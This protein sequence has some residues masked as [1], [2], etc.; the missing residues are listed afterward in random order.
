MKQMTGKILSGLAVMTLC[1]TSCHDNAVFDQPSYNQLVKDAFPVKNVDPN[2]TWATVGTATAEVSLDLDQDV[3]YDVVLY[4]DNPIG[5]SLATRVYECKMTSGESLTTNFSYKLASPVVYVGVFDQEGRGLA[6]AVTIEDGRAVAKISTHQ[7]ASARHRAAEN[8]A[9]YGQFVKSANDYLNYNGF[10]LYGNTYTTRQISIAGMQAYTALTDADLQIGVT[11]NNQTLSDLQY[12]SDGTYYIAHGDGKHYRIPAGT[13]LTSMFNINGTWGVLNDAV[14]YVEGKMHLNGNT[15][16]GPTLVVANGGEIIVDGNTNMSNAGRII[17]LAGG[18]MTGANGVTYN[19]N[20]AGPSYNAGTIEFKGELNTNGSDFYN[21]ATG[22]IKLDVL[23]NT[24]GGK[25]TNFGKI[26]ARTNTIQGDAYNCHIINGC[27]MHFTGNAGVGGITMLDNSRLDVDGQLYITGK[28]QWRQGRNNT[29]YHQSLI[30][31]QSMYFQGA[32][33]V[34]PTNNGEFAIVK[35]SKLLVSYADD[36]NSYDNVFWDI[37][38][39][40]FYNYQNQKWD[41]NNIYTAAWHILNNGSWCTSGMTHYIDENTTLSNFQIPASDCTGE[42]YN[43]GGNSGGGKPESQDLSMRFLFEDNFP[44]AGDYDMNDCVFKVT[45][46][47]DPSNSKKVNVTV[48]AEASGAQKSIGAAI[49][50]KGVTTSMLSKYECTQGF[51]VPPSNVGSYDNIPDGS[52]TISKDP[53]D[54]SSLVMLLFKDMHWVLNPNEKSSG[55]VDVKYYNTMKP[56]NSNSE[57]YA[58][59]DVKTAT[60][61][62]EFNF[63]KDAQRML[64]QATYDA[65]IVEPY[66]GSWWEVHTVQNDFKGAL[67]LHPE[68]HESTYE[69]YL[70]AYVKSEIG[71]LPWAVMVPGTVAYPYEWVKIGS[72]DT[73]NSNIEIAYPQFMGWA[74]NKEDNV[75][76]YSHPAAGKTWTRP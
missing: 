43:D 17:I 73:N 65:F 76:W 61:V 55:G 2:Q 11:T 18:K 3:T 66:N 35:T 10:S 75:D 37:D 69:A 59:A 13:E 42:G 62:F 8:A 9:I 36:I 34:G 60:Y 16:N 28:E 70:N 31:A 22:N 74:R 26:E 58:V 50:L 20:N 24:S 33:F 56:E 51:P 1:L 57:W 53:N 19:I 63:E 71:N 30:N 7:S 49:R 54:K 40:E 29:L 27:Y 64:D 15:L 68:V 44:D 47:I 6:Q 39:N 72:D 5:S 21:A 45:P 52:F 23:R 14:I 32:G 41:I 48:T 25:Y 4:L 12:R 67:V 38:K 46:Q